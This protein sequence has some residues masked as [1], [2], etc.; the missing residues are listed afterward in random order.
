MC[1]RFVA[2]GPKSRWHI[3]SFDLYNFLFSQKIIAL[4]LQ[5]GSL[6]LEIN[7]YNE[8]D[9]HRITLTVFV[10]EIPIQIC[11]QN[12]LIQLIKDNFVWLKSCGCQGFDLSRKKRDG[13]NQESLDLNTLAMISFRKFYS[14]GNISVA[15][16]M[17][18]RCW[19][20]LHDSLFVK[21]YLPLWKI[22]YFL[23][24]IVFFSSQIYFYEDEI[25]YSSGI[26]FAD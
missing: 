3:Y 15:S 11:M 19:K 4:L 25:L 8:N 2:Y 12:S 23:H 10:Y 14:I 1:I 24:G 5:I 26:H 17:I 18:N 16:E 21:Q 22:E 9:Y 13:G 6:N 20:H 7:T